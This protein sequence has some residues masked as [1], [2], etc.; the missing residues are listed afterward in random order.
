MNNHPFN[1]ARYAPL[2]AIADQAEADAAFLA[3]VEDHLRD[4]DLDPADANARAAVEAAER[5]NLAVYAAL[6]EPRAFAQVERLFKTDHRYYR[7]DAGTV[8]PSP[9]GEGRDEGGIKN[10]NEK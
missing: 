10:R 1:H 6:N 7:T 3:L 5:N 8:S 2:M 9:G 4:E